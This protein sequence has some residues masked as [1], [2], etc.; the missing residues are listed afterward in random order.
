MECI[1]I[2]ESLTNFNFIDDS[3]SCNASSNFFENAS[4]HLLQAEF[5]FCVV[6]DEFRGGLEFQMYGPSSFSFVPGQIY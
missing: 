5:M 6:W 3:C 4:V 1:A 2:S